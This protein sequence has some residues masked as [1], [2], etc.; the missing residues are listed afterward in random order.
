MSLCHGLE[1]SKVEEYKLNTANQYGLRYGQ[2]ST[3][4]A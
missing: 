1:L 2:K 3:K 4:V